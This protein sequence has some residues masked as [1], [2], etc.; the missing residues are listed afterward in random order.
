[1][2]AMLNARSPGLLVMVGEEETDVAQYVRQRVLDA[3]SLLIPCAE[4]EDLDWFRE[5]CFLVPQLADS[6]QEVIDYL[7]R[8]APLLQG[9]K[10]AVCHEALEEA[11]E[12]LRDGHMS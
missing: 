9:E 12:V 4:N 1:M 8:S 7:R 6:S 5:F 2:E 10:Q 11:E 3:V